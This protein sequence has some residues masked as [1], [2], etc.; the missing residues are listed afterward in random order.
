MDSKFGGR[1]LAI[2][3][4]A[5]F[6]AAPQAV[7][8]ATAD[9]NIVVNDAGDSLVALNIQGSGEFNVPL[10]LDAAN[11]EVKGALFVPAENG[12]DVL[13]GPSGKASIAYDTSLLTA[14]SG[15]KWVLRKFALVL[16]IF[17]IQN[18]V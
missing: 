3:L 1:L 16:L 8:A 4:L 10:P 15:G 2:T 12:I 7:R 18:L 11:P 9:Y 5:L 14:K 13:V 6:L 17:L